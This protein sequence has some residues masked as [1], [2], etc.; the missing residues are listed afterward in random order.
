MSLRL[1][2]AVCLA[3]VSL[4][5]H[6]WANAFAPQT[7]MYNGACD[8]SAAVTLDE[9]HFAI[10]DDED[11]SNALRVYRFGNPKPVSVTPT[12]DFLHVSAEADIEGVERVGALIYWIGSHSRTSR[13]K[14]KPSRDRLFATRLSYHRGVP[15]LTPSGVPY[16]HLLDDLENARRLKQLGLTRSAGLPPEAAGGLNIEAL[17]HIGSQ[18]L[19]GFRSPQVDGKAIVLAIKNPLQLVSTPGVRAQ[20]G[21]VSLLALGGRGVRGMA[22]LPDSTIG[23]IAGP[24]DDHADFALYRWHGPGTPA[25]QSARMDFG[26]LHPEGLFVRRPHDIYAVS[27]D[28]PTV[29]DG[30]PCSQWPFDGPD[31]SRKHFRVTKLPL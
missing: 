10:A 3:A 30:K 2:G 19:V 7:E 25:L 5:V 14:A 11:P 23:I 31:A 1:V 29:V 16:S 17:G 4:H 27:D 8:A 22:T 28:G 13:D 21:S 18:L 9:N 12:S 15:V 6:S 26:T 20:I 24:T